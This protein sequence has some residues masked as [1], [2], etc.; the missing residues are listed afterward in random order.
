MNTDFELRSN[1]GFIKD[2]PHQR[3]SVD[4]QKNMSYEN[5]NYKN[6]SCAGLPLE[7]VPQQRKNKGANRNMKTIK[8]K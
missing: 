6:D 1:S 8:T 5:E 2:K 4:K 7:P 3:K